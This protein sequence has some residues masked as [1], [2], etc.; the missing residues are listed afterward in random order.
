MLSQI[1]A[2]S[3]KSFWMPQRASSV[4]ADVDDPD[5]L[6]LLDSNYDVSVL[7]LEALRGRPAHLLVVSRPGQHGSAAGARPYADD[8]D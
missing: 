5:L 6:S 8:S 3:S 7:R 4:A 2:N 1:L